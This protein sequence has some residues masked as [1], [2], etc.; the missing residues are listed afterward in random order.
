MLGVLRGAP[1]AILRVG[2]AIET[3]CAWLGPFVRP[4]PAA[5]FWPLSLP[6]KGTLVAGCVGVVGIV[7]GVTWL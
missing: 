4:L 5:Q 3:G 7:A 1:S 2:A 6:D